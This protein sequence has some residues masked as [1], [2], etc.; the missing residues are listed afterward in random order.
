[1]IV[2]VED[3]EHKE[4]N[5]FEEIQ[6]GYVVSTF[7]PDGERLIKQKEA[8]TEPATYF[9]ESLP[10]AFLRMIPI[11]NENRYSGIELEPLATAKSPLYA[12]E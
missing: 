1:M 6:P 2:S 8:G 4:E 9:L 7:L 11:R 12:S 10:H 3:V 5:S